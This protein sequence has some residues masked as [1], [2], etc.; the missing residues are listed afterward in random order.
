MSHII[1]E[2]SIKSD[3]IEVFNS[4]TRPKST[5]YNSTQADSQTQISNHTNGTIL[6]TKQGKV[7][8]V[9]DFARGCIR[10]MENLMFFTKNNVIRSL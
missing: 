4:P 10:A 7:F 2:S 6:F 8:D 5:S 9:N 1:I 3:E